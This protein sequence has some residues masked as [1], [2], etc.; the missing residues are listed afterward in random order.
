MEK[1]AKTIFNSLRDKGY[2]GEKLINSFI[3]VGEM[4][5]EKSQ[6]EGSKEIAEVAFDIFDNVSVLAKS[7]GFK[8]LSLKANNLAEQ[9]KALILNLD[10]G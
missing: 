10:S 4:L 7:Q 5:L 6:K 9:A 2:K 1:Q 3:N 8:P